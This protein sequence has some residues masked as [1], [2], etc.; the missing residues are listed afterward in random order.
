MAWWILVFTTAW[1]AGLFYE[2]VTARRARKKLAHVVHVNG[3][4]GKSTVS[5]MIEAGLRA[6][7][8]AGFCKTTGTDAM[9]IDVMG[10]E[11][12]VRRRGK[13]NI[14]EQIKILRQAAEQ[15]CIRDRIRG[16]AMM[17]QAVVY[18]HG[19]GGDPGEAVH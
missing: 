6:G 12:A 15:M 4:R 5:R 17:A 16:A 13:A 8:V 2:S 3:T 9:I 7:G 11:K 14:K 10:R 1:L 18:I 19:K